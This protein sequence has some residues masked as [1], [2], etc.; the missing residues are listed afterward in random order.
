M[1][2]I[3]EYACI[4]LMAAVAFASCQNTTVPALTTRTFGPQEFMGLLSWLFAISLLTERALEVVISVFRD[5]GRKALPSETVG[6]YQDETRRLALML[7]FAFGI[8]I[9]Y[10]GVR[11]LSTL[12]DAGQRSSRLFNWVDIVVTGAVIAGGSQGIHL[13]ANAFGDFTDAV[14]ARSKQAQRD[15]TPTT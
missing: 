10:S 1:T 2:K 13:I 11:S 6:A 14:S 7:G 5:G 9:A 12:I 8:A 15:A 3:I 4:L